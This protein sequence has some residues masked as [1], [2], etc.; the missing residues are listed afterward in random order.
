MSPSATS[1]VNPPRSRRAAPA[2][3]DVLLAASSLL[4]LDPLALLLCLFFVAD[5]THCWP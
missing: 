1:A 4:P 3:P 2:P 5:C